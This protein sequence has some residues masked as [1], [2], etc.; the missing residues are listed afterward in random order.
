M[1]VEAYV[2]IYGEEYRPLITQAMAWLDGAEPK[3]GLKSA[4]DRNTFLANLI[5]EAKRGQRVANNGGE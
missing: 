1:T 3:W 5:S 2:A 4:I